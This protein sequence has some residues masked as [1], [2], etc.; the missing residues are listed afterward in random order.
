MSVFKFGSFYFYF[1][2]KLDSSGLLA[3]QK[4]KGKLI[5]IKYPRPYRSGVFYISPRPKGRG[6]WKENNLSL[7]HYTPLICN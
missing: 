2:K 1:G 5:Y 7:V 3:L 6:V 4:T